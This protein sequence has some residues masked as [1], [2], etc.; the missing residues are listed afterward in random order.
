MCFF[1]KLCDSD[2]KIIIKKKIKKWK[3]FSSKSFLED[4]FQYDKND[5]DKFFCLEE[6]N[7]I[8]PFHKPSWISL[9]DNI[10]TQKSKWKFLWKERSDVA[11][12]PRA[13]WRTFS[14]PPRAC[15]GQRHS[16]S[17]REQRI[18]DL[19]SEP[20]CSGFHIWGSR[21]NRILWDSCKVFQGD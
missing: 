17:H 15:A 5:L 7:I 14:Y 18:G 6:C 2:Q 3:Q 11:G 4:R 21:A 13:P 12:K 20:M 16:W 9:V 1:F 8:S 10:S 19:V